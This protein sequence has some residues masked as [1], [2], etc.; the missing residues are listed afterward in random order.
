MTK[1]SCLYV[2]D[3]LR[4]EDVIKLFKPFWRTKVDKLKNV[5]LSFFNTDPKIT[6]LKIKLKNVFNFFFF[7][8]KRVYQYVY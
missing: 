6:E 2:A 7:L 5:S 4:I 3:F 8:V 1:T